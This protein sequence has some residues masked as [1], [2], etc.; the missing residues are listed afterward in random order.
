[1]T[2]ASAESLNSDD[3]DEDDE[4]GTFIAVHQETAE[5]QS[6]PS[7]SFVQIDPRCIEEEEDYAEEIVSIKDSSNDSETDDDECI[8]SG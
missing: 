2:L 4:D 3:F 5:H 7:T 1:M 6:P 8:K